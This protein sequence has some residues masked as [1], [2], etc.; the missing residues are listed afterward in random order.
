MNGQADIYRQLRYKMVFLTFILGV[1]SLLNACV[2]TPVAPVRIP[3]LAYPDTGQNAYLWT[4]GTRSLGFMDQRDYAYIARIND[5]NIPDEY[6]PDEWGVEPYYTWLL[7]I[8]AGKHTIEIV[9]KERLTF[10]CGMFGCPAYEQSRQTL[11]FNADP[12]RTYSPFAA[13]LLIPKDRDEH[14]EGF[15]FER[16]KRECD[17]HYFW[18]EDWGSY[19][20]GSE[21]RRYTEDHTTDLTKPVVAGEVPNQNNLCE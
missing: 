10:F 1:I 16:S 7:E 5:V 6:V 14:L 9:Y 17:Q 13:D 8:P 21:T 19:V 3:D 2:T 11:T 12:N 20:T 15:R 4:V 18:I